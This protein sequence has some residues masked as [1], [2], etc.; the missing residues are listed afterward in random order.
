MGQAVAAYHREM[1]RH[2]PTNIRFIHL[3]ENAA[4][5]QQAFAAIFSLTFHSFAMASSSVPTFRDVGS[6]N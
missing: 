3:K 4:G 5:R 1:M 2:D 6:T